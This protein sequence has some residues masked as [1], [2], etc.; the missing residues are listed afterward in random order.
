MR[1]LLKILEVDKLTAVSP[2]NAGLPGQT[3]RK[4][5]A[6]QELGKDVFL[7]LLVAQLRHQDPLNPQDNS[8]FVAQMAQFTALEQMQ[9]L[10]QLLGRMLDLQAGVQAPALLDRWVTVKE[11]GGEQRSGRVHAVEYTSGT[12]WLIVSGRRYP[13][14]AVQ[15]VEPADASREA[16]SD[17]VAGEK[18]VF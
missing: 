3:G 1:K 13:L 7:K 5:G 18:N 2:V 9:N 4:T 12:P 11:E 16:V 14:E 10:N 8:A 15:R 6:M 17:N